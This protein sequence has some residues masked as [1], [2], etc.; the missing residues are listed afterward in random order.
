MAKNEKSLNPLRYY[1]VLSFGVAYSFRFRVV[2]WK[3]LTGD[4]GMTGRPEAAPLYRC[5]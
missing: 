4:L 2:E 3:T 5:G 1:P